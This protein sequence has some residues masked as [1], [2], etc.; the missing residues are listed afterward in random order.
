MLLM[1]IES[2][3]I[4]RKCKYEGCT[5]VLVIFI[6]SFDMAIN[7]SMHASIQVAILGKFVHKEKDKREEDRLSSRGLGSDAPYIPHPS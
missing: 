3:R 6:R 5:V 2:C 7:L 4:A 1:V